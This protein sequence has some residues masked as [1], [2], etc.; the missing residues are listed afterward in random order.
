MYLG[1]VTADHGI[2]R[3]VEKVPEDGE[4]EFVAIEFGGLHDI[5]N[6]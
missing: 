3:R 6:H 2:D 5:G 1:I 4:T